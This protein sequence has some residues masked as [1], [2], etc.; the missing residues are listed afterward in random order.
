MACHLV[1]VKHYLNQCWYMDYSNLRNKFQWNLKWNS[2]IF[3][4]GIAFENVVYGMAASFPRPQCVNY[5]I[6]SFISWNF[7]SFPVNIQKCHNEMERAYL[8][9]LY[10]HWDCWRL[11]GQWFS[12]VPEGGKLFLWYMRKKC[13]I[14]IKKNWQEKVTSDPD[15]FMK[16]SF[17]SMRICG[18]SHVNCEIMIWTLYFSSCQ[19]HFTYC[20]HG[21]RQFSC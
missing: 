1:G 20:H 4:Q 15:A 11:P 6:S 19:P 18:K 21:H 5:E 2:Y 9:Q 10:N 14:S 12:T 3:V 16:F 13:E 8:W 7:Y 17:L